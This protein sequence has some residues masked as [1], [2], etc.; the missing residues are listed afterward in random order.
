MVIHLIDFDNDSFLACGTDFPG[1]EFTRDVE[2]VTCQHC[3][4]TKKYKQEV[5]Q[6][7]A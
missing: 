3:M 1:L 4:N 6:T 5:N 7:E 2:A